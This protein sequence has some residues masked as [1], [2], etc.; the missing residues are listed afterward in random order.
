MKYIRIYTESKSMN[1]Y[2]Y[3]EQTGEMFILEQSKGGNGLSV[4]IIAGISLVIYAFVGK[5]EKPISFDANLLYW[6]SVRIGVALGVLIAGYMLKRAKRKIEKKCKNLSLWTK[7]KA[8]NGKTESQI[9]F[10]IHFSD[11]CHGWDMCS[12]SFPNDMGC[13]IRPGICFFKFVDV[14]VDDFT[15]N[16]FYR[17]SSHKGMENCK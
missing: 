8:G 13:S 12:L 11:S 14:L 4:G 16:R 9:F 15:D 17:K 7:R 3:E 10:Y 5:I 6:I 2:Y 1:N